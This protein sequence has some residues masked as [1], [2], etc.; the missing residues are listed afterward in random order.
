MGIFCMVFGV[1]VFGG[2]VAFGALLPTFEARFL[3]R[4][5]ACYDVQHDYRTPAALHAR[6]RLHRPFDRPVLL[7][8]GP[9]LSEGQQ[10]RA[11]PP[12]ALIK[13]RERKDRP[14]RYKFRSDFCFHGLRACA[15]A[16]PVR[17]ICQRF[18][19]PVR[20]GQG[21]FVLPAI[22]TRKRPASPRLPGETGRSAVSVRC[23]PRRFPWTA[24]PRGRRLRRA[25]HR[26]RSA[27][28]A[29]R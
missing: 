22:L 3:H 18:E 29:P 19:R 27:R 15:D 24:A 26:A 5:P 11:P 9:D 14:G 28:R 17:P 21:R 13:R 1:V 2:F 7:H 25:A 16:Q 20:Q 6:V 10:D 4:R 8:A 12:R 23:A